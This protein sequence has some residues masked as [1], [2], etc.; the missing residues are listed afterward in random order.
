MESKL[1][2]DTAFSIAEEDGRKIIDLDTKMDKY[3]LLALLFHKETAKIDSSKEINVVKNDKKRYFE[4]TTMCY[5]CG[6]IGHTSR[7]CKVVREVNCMYCDTYHNRKPCDFI[8]CDNCLYLGH[9]ARWCRSKP[10]ELE[11]C[12]DCPFQYHYSDE[13]P[14]IWRK[15][16]ILGNSKATKDNI[17]M[18]CPCCQSSSHF[19]DDCPQK[20]RRF[21]IFTKDYM[22]IIEKPKPN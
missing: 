7:N 16:K 21:S 6:D 5:N 19:M 3:E 9:S 18:S 10:Y 8:L 17:I 15:Y 2:W 12:T 20:D 1:S 14:R 22:K 11:V 13:C 4:D